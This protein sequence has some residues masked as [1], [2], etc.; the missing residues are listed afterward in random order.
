[1]H[2]PAGSR[3]APILSC[4]ARGQREALRRA[5]APQRWPLDPA[6]LPADALLVGG[7]VRDALLGR[8]GERPDLDLVVE[9][10][11]LAL[12]RGLA[13]RCGGSCVVLD[14]ERS[15]ARLVI[16]GWS[17]DLARRMGESLE[18]DLARRDYSVN[19]IALPLAA[20]CGGEGD[21]IDPGGGLADLRAR[22][23]RALGEA[24]LLEDPLRLLR[25]VRLACELDFTI[26]AETLSWIRIH[27]RRLREVAGERVLAELERLAAAPAGGDGLLQV[28]RLGLLQGWQGD[29]A[30][31][32]DEESGDRTQVWAAQWLERLTPECAQ[33]CGLQPEEE[34]WALPLGRLAALLTPAALAQLRAS[35]RLQ[36]RARRLRH[37]LQRLK[38][39]QVPGEPAMAP[40]VAGIR[41]GELTLAGLGEEDRL[42]LQRELEEDLP[43]LALHLEPLEAREALKRWRD[44]GDPLF[45]PRPPLDGQQ[46]Q[47]LLGIPAGRALGALL[48]HLT[49]E[50]AFGRLAASTEPEPVLE[51]ARHWLAGCGDTGAEPAGGRAP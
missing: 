14:A 35:R 48:A 9:G 1:M 13:R 43:A 42:A 38:Q 20:L 28:L 25:G 6:Q 11:A 30:Q 47:L 3:Q 33:D 18:Q 19:A 41:H 32:P 4:D 17:F 10:D 23:M 12:A 22:R 8:L 36:Q 39:G 40:A 27:H 34:S 5:L 37:W 16:Q 2:M 51:V 15:I 24:N 31:P 50:R 26:D 45:H 21:P 44:E 7:A 29:E 49:R 46:L